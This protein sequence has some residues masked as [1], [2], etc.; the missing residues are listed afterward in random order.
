MSIIFMK[1][2]EKSGIIV[3]GILGRN[4]KFEQTNHMCWN[5]NCDL[6]NFQ[7]TKIQTRWLHRQ[8]LTK[9]LRIVNT[10]PSHGRDGH[11][12]EWTLG[13]GDGQGGLECFNSWG[14]KES[15]RTEWLNWTELNIYYLISSLSHLMFINS[16]QGKWCYYVVY[17]F[18][19]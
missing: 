9:T 19:T 1:F 18:Y 10:Y 7:Q 14:R 12:F 5:W 17:Q 11:E 3:F 2:P 15:D 8:I 13:L 16:L 6:K 4:K